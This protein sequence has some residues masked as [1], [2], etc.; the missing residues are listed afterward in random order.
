M[1]FTTPRVHV[2]DEVEEV[3]SFLGALLTNAGYEV[4]CYSSAPEFLERYRPSLPQC[5]LLDMRLP[6]VTGLELQRQLKLHGRDQDLPVILMSGHGSTS[7]V[8]QAFKQGA[9]DFLEK[10]LE[11]EVLLDA[12][13]HAIMKNEAQGRTCAA[14]RK[15]HAQL[16]ALTPREREVL[17][18]VARGLPSKNIANSLS[19]SRKTV[20]L[21]RA[22]VMRKL[23][24]TSVAELVRLSLMANAPPAPAT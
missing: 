8:I 23:G 10:P 17:E 11:P 19:I 24:A 13:Q 7:A 6:L 21:H 2:V 14:R 16:A 9:E 3:R 20:D 15:A 12:I 22:N 5:L 4:L 1:A 18:L